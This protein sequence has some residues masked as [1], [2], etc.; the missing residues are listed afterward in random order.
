MS[1]MTSERRQLNHIEEMLEE[2]VGYM[3]EKR[4]EAEDNEFALNMRESSCTQ[5]E[6]QAATRQHKRRQ[7]LIME[8]KL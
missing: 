4:R 1:R 8:G 3:R 2:L 7:R 5:R 6:R